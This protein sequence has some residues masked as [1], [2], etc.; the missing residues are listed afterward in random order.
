MS[1]LQFTRNRGSSVNKLTPYPGSPTDWTNLY[2]ALKICQNISVSAISNR[3]TIISLD[4]QLYAKAMQLKAKQDINENVVFRLGELH[5]VFAFLKTIGKYIECSGLDQIFVEA[6]IYG[7]TTLDQIL[8]GNHMKRAMEAYMVQYIGLYKPYLATFFQEHPDPKQKISQ[9]IFEFTKN[10]E[11][12]YPHII[13][14]KHLSLLDDFNESE[15]FMKMQNES[16]SNQAYILRNVMSMFDILL[17]FTRATRQGK[18]EL[19]FKVH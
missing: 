12:R 15:I 19:H 11:N 8:N 5:I 2:A 6:N 7:S 17:L 14:P 16:L 3:K 9:L 18:W 4:L 13:N 1:S 10:I